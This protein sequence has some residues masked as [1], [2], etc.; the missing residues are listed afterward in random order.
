MA[1]AL[2]ALVRS[3][4]LPQ[5][6]LRTQPRVSTLGGPPR[7]TRPEGATDRTC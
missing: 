2:T 7:A 6:G 4:N 5:R 3:E 1:D